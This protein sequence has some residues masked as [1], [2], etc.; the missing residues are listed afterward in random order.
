MAGALKLL[1]YVFACVCMFTPLSAN[2]K[3]AT[4]KLHGDTIFGNGVIFSRQV[5]GSSLHSTSR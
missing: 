1:S 5:S 4:S 3:T 2:G